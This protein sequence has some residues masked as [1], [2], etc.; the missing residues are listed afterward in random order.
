MP[1]TE[2]KNYLGKAGLVALW[3]K[4]KSTFASKSEL[5]QKE[6]LNRIKGVTIDGDT[7][8]MQEG[9]YAEWLYS[10]IIVNGEQVC[11]ILRVTNGDNEIIDVKV[12]G[13]NN[14]NGAYNLIISIADRIFNL[15]P[16][17]QNELYI[18]PSSIYK[19]T[20]DKEDKVAI[21]TAVNDTD[22]TLPITSLTCET[23]KYYKVEVAVET[24]N[25]MLPA[26]TNNSNVQ[27]VVLFLTAGTTPAVTFTSQN[28]ANILYHE[29]YGIA[30]GRT[31]EINCL[32]NGSAW[33]I[34]SLE[35]V[36]P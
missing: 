6:Q 35:I 28:G 27:T 21:V 2:D 24:I 32:W 3:G 8:N 9:D 13:S 36:K 12:L 4:I 18:A 33:V 19:Y 23:G 15:T 1:Q 30:S 10:N 31:Y 11:D 29:G 16:E 20:K 26:I 25:I 17:S 14:Y 34:A 22:A 5:P 7:V